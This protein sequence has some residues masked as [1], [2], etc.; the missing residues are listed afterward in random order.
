MLAALEKFARQ[1]QAACRDLDSA[2]VEA[3]SI[4]ALHERGESTDD[5]WRESRQRLYMAEH[6]RDA[7][8]RALLFAAQNL[9]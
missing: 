9:P 1:Y 4:E 5:V 8:E 3:E 2:K 6:A 7:F